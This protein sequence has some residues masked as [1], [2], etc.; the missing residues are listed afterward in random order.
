AGRIALD[1]EHEL[2][3]DEHARQRHLDAGVE[4][5]VSARFP[6]QPHRPG[7]VR[8]GDGPAIGS[9]HQGRENLLRRAVVLNWIDGRWSAA[10]PAEASGGGGRLQPSVWRP[11]DPPTAWRVADRGCAVRTDD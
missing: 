3:A 4:V 1:A 5:A 8:L 10:C 2:G 7:E 6:I 9:A 11:E